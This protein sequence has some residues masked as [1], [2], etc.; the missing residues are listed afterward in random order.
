MPGAP[1]GGILIHLAGAA[2]ARSGD[3]A[4]MYRVPEVDPCRGLGSDEPAG[5]WAGL[6]HAA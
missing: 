6:P 4:S 5:L 1:G 3:G 2:D